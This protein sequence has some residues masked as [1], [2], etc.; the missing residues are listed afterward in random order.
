MPPGF[1][2]VTMGSPS[3]YDLDFRRSG[4]EVEC[5]FPGQPDGVDFF[6]FWLV[7]VK[8]LKFGGGDDAAE[9]GGHVGG[10][11]QGR[12]PVS[13]HAGPSLFPVRSGGRP[14][15]AALTRSLVVQVTPSGSFFSSSPGHHGQRAADTRPADPE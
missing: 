5:V 4:S 7:R 1:D 2:A 13:L 3:R 10:R 6:G 14:W 9:L 15:S 11:G 12:E 8:L